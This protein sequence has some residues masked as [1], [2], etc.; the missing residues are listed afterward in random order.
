MNALRLAVV[1][2]LAPPAAAT[3]GVTIHYKGTVRSAEGVQRVLSEARSFARVQGWKVEAR[4]NG[5]VLTA[6]SLCE[7]IEL[8]FH[9]AEL[10]SSWVKTQFAPTEIHI[11]VVNLFRK[12]APLFS[13]LEITDEAAYWDTGDREKLERAIAANAAAQAKLAR[14]QGYTG[15]YRVKPEAAKDKD[16]KMSG[17][18]I[19]L[20]LGPPPPELEPLSPVKSR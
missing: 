2:A 3:A 10:E 6:H 4:P 13:T 7:P 16:A 1:L 18:I 19:D 5:I 14:E 11:A 17:R 9:G 15:P 8:L 20:V 12:V